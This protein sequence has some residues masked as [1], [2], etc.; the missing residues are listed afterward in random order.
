MK[1]VRVHE[2]GDHTVLRY[3]DVSTPE[4]ASGEVRVKVAAAG[5]NFIDTYHRQ[6]WYPL[7]R[8]FI[9]GQDGAGTVD[10]LGAGVTGFKVGDTVAWAQQQGSY[11]EYVCAGVAKLIP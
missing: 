5:L 10:K 4:P 6:G 8:P 11:A 9:L 7:P 1:A 2:F 3:E